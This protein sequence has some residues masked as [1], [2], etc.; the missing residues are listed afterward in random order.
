MAAAS[1]LR[2]KD[3]ES[4]S[5][6]IISALDTEIKASQ[7]IW[8]SR[9]EVYDGIIN[10]TDANGYVYTFNVEKEKSLPPETPILL[11]FEDYRDIS[12]SVINCGNYQI[13][14]KLEKYIGNYVE[15]AFIRNSPWQIDEKLRDRFT[16]LGENGGL[17]SSR[18]RVLLGFD[19]QMPAPDPATLIDDESLKQ[20]ID[21]VSEHID[22]DESKSDSVSKCAN[23]GLHFIWGPPGTGKTNNLAQIA[24]LHNILGEKVMILSTT[25]VAVDTAMVMVAKAFKDTPGLNQGKV[26]RIG[27]P[28]L[29]EAKARR[30]I[31]PFEVVKK[32]NP[33]LV[34]KLKNINEKLSGLRKAMKMSNS[35]G[36]DMGQSLSKL[37]SDKKS[38]LGEFDQK[39]EELITAAE[40]VGLT[41][42]KH[43]MADKMFDWNADTI[44][45]DE[46]SMVK[47]PYI[48][49][50]AMKAGKRLHIFG[51]FKQLAPICQS[52][53][54]SNRDEN[55]E[56]WLSRDVY[57]ISG[58]K[59]RV[60]KNGS[61][62]MVTML[63][64]QY[65]M[66]REIADLV[67]EFAYSGLLVTPDEVHL[68]TMDLSNYPPSSG[69]PV[70]L[71]NT[72]NLHPG[73]H[74]EYDSKYNPLHALLAV[75]LVRDLEFKGARNISVIAPYRAQAD[76]I[77]RML[78]KERHYMNVKVATIHSFQG[79]ESDIVIFD[80]VDSYPLSKE[81]S[82]HLTGISED[83]MRIF[84]VAMSRPRGKLIVL[85]NQRF[86]EEIHT[87]ESYGNIALH[88]IEKHGKVVTLSPEAMTY[89]PGVPDLEWHAS[90]NELQNSVCTR[91]AQVTENR[92]I[93]LNLPWGYRLNDKLAG[94]ILHCSEKHAVTVND[95]GCMNETLD[96]PGINYRI[97]NLTGSLT[98]L[99]DNEFAAIGG[100]DVNGGSGILTNRHSISA[101]KQMKNLAAKSNGVKIRGMIG[102]CKK[103][104]RRLLVQGS[105]KHWKFK[106]PNC[107]FSYDLDR[108]LLFW[109]MLYLGIKCS[110]CGSSAKARGGIGDLFTGCS[111]YRECG[112]YPPKIYTVMQNVQSML[113]H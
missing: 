46:A 36:E 6:E 11:D 113:N 31:I 7:K 49:V 50:S 65:R 73:C 18:P 12:G 110:R 77:K 40:V 42:S 45:I 57:E 23:S 43:V 88:L 17:N 51:D 84:N 76:L 26:L 3:L 69:E 85:A 66:R 13:R 107:D 75:Q 55:V 80:T 44:L 82:C 1:D 106:C 5:S 95:V 62:P 58:I 63:N 111:D 102:N 2:I 108:D 97:Y 60:L 33:D 96:K 99:A 24:R 94:E 27:Y 98:I 35:P 29:D 87:P 28:V 59:E 4:V 53:E 112:G 109:I 89:M 83:A 72:E 68:R 52:S 15:E 101:V 20:L 38:I 104:G 79:S 14:I 105:N 10:D 37:E 92:E 47:F 41:L 86:F 34:R 93:F 16:S 32:Q 103:C 8:N 100:I 22:I 9:L 19:N 39:Q 56:T 64:K 91:L 78:R 81:R 30:E 25:N 71:M 54:A 61:D 21:D 74:Y 90:W 70:V 67:S 48:L